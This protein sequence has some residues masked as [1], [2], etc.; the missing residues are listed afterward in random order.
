MLSQ[1]REL[2]TVRVCIFIVRKIW[3]FFW[4]LTKDALLNLQMQRGKNRIIMK[5]KLEW[6]KFVLTRPASLQILSNVVMVISQQHRENTVVVYKQVYSYKVMY[7]KKDIQ[8]S[9]TENPWICVLPPTIT[10]EQMN[11]Y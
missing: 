2:H 4:Q 8:C 6:L 9:V 10:R 1:I 7:Y 5:E 11:Y 3:K